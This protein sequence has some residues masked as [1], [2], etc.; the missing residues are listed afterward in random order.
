MKLVY[1]LARLIVILAAINAGLYG[2]FDMDLIVSLAGGS[3][4]SMAKF[5]YSVIGVCGLISVNRYR[6]RLF[7][8]SKK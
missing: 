5:I 6:T 3:D 4:T 2:F 7:E 8:M 1:M